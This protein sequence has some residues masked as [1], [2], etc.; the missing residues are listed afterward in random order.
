MEILEK[1]QKLKKERNAVILVHNYQ[2]PEVQDI[3]DF[4]GDSYGLSVQASKTQADVIV[5]CGVYFMAETAK[6]LSP[7]KTVV[8]P[9]PDAGCPMADMI[10]AE[11]LRELKREHPRAK[12]MCYVN[13][14]A[15]V[16]AEC[17]LCCT[18]ANAVEILNN[19]FSPEDE[20]L[21]VPDKYLATYAASQ[22]GKKIIFWEGNCPTHLGGILPRDV[23][24]RKKEHPAAQVMV[25]PECTPAVT[26]LADKVLSTSG[27]LKYARES[28][29]REFIIGTEIGIL[30]ALKK[31]NPGKNF[32]PVSNHM[33]CPNMKKINLNKV[34]HSLETLSYEV[35]LPQEI[36]TKAQKS[37]HNMLLAAKDPKAVAAAL[38]K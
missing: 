15:E 32:Y 28:D 14:S 9:D 31:E 13:T 3:A 20:I 27:M 5:F 30:H 6:I 34:L 2:L 21:F 22:T 7:Q 25:H 33:I 38:V 17:D 37:L 11:Q 8:I 16:K 1:I 4:T 12:V 24:A 29:A 26:Q 35:K 18:S 10:T 36:I 23:L 19:V